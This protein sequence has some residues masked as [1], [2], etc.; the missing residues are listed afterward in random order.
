MNGI[1]WEK[2]YRDHPL[3]KQFYEF[4]GG[5]FGINPRSFQLFYLDNNHKSHKLPD[6]EQEFINLITQSIEQGK[7]LFIQGKHYTG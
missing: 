3:T 6:N 1:V 7:N 2:K 4:F 5:Q